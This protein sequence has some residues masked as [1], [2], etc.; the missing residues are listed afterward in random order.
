M[1][2]FPKHVLHFLCVS[3]CMI[4]SANSFFVL[5][6]TLTKGPVEDLWLRS[7]S[8]YE[9]FITE[10]W[11]KITQKWKREKLKKTMSSRFR[12]CWII[13]RMPVS[14]E[15]P[16]GVSFHS[17]SILIAVPAIVSMGSV[18]DIENGM[19]KTGL[20]VCWVLWLWICHA[21]G[22]WGHVIFNYAS[23]LEDIYI[24]IWEYEF[25]YSV[26]LLCC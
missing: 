1:M 20:A 16:H 9:N 18:L 24:Y 8:L 12:I 7:T 22:Q 4:W 26:F 14:V 17:I 3:C 6:Q 11:Q 10:S 19:T 25:F 23:K 2:R 5:S 15:E 13:N 21:A